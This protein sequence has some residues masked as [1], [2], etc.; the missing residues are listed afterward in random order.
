LSEYDGVSDPR[1][2]LQKYT[3]AISSRGWCSNRKSYDNG[4]EGLIS[5]MVCFATKMKH[6]IMGTAS[7]E[8]REQLSGVLPSFR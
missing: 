5:T 2:F 6:Q 7:A 8:N 4:L 3:V 1:Q